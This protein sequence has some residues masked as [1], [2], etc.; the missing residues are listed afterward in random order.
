MSEKKRKVI[1]TVTQG[2]ENFANAHKANVSMCQ[3]LALTQRKD[4]KWRNIATIR[5]MIQNIDD[6]YYF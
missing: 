2:K 5:Y 3:V 1:A 6:V 4:V